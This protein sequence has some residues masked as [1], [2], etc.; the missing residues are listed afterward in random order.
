MD[1]EIVADLGR[2]EA[3]ARLIEDLH[4]RCGPVAALV[5][6]AA[7]RPGAPAEFAPARWRERLAVDLRGLF[8]LVQ[9][10]APDLQ[11]AASEG[12]AAVLAATAM[13]G[14][15]GVEASGSFFAGHGGLVGFLKTLAQ[16]WPA[17]RV[18]AVDL[19]P[20]DPDQQ[21]AWLVD[22]L[23]A[24]DGVVEVGY[25]DGRRT[26]LALVPA[27]L[28][29]RPDDLRLDD[30]S[31]VLITGGARGITAEVA[32]ALAERYRPTLLLVGRTP[33]PA[34][35]EGPEIAGLSD[36]VALRRALLVRRQR[37][38][39]PVVPALIEADYQR[40]LREREV[41]RN[42]SRLRAT[43]AQVHYHVGDVREA[44][45]FGR[46][47]TALSERYGRIDGVIHGAGVIED[48]LVVDK[49][50]DS[51]ERVIA[52]KV[53]SA[54]VLATHLRPETVRFL[55]FFSSFSGRFGN[56]GQSDYAAACEILSKLAWVLDRR[57]P[58]RVVAIDW[59]PWTGVGMVSPT[60]ER[61]FRARG[62][63]LIRPAEGGRWLLAEVQG[64]AQAGGR[65]RHR[66]ARRLGAR[67]R[68]PARPD[69]GCPTGSA[70]AD[71]PGGGPVPRAGGG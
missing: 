12:G 34:A 23:L 47:L 8:Q 51:F 7:L 28:A 16:E 19:G 54:L 13:G 67:G 42:L 5:F 39:E 56:R 20:A 59:G 61:Q 60:V 40:L 52:T 31:V 50:L 43:G 15:F 36:P 38:G 41:R 11:R 53:E 63:A 25:A 14:T 18:K 48:R 1:S 46:L 55:V 49:T 17:V 71:R 32:V 10:L 2:P 68:R 22:E 37:A 70:A 64:G 21:A 30:R 3:V 66:R 27:P 4:Q 69:G 57:W 45:A 35:E 65:G 9:G 44:A 58:G 29:D 24:A 26:T 33:L 62:V 6:L